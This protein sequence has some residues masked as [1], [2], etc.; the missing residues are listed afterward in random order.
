MQLLARLMDRVAGEAQQPRTIVGATSGD[1]G[2]A[3]IE[4]FRGSRARRCGDP[5]SRGPRLR[6]AAAHDDDADRGERARRRRRRH[7]RRL[8][9]AREGD[10]QRPRLPRSRVTGRRQL[11]QLGP[12]RRTGD[13]LFRRR[14][15]PRRAVPSALVLVPTGNF[16]DIFAGWVASAWA[17][18]SSAGHRLER[19][20]HPAAHARERHYEMRGVIADSSPSMDIQISSNFERYLFEASGRDASRS[21]TRCGRWRNRQFRSR[22]RSRSHAARFR[23]RRRERG[24]SRRRDP[25]PKRE[26][27]YLADPHTACGMVAPRKR[28]RHAARRRSCS[29]PPIRPS[30][31]TP[32]R[33]SPASGR[34]CPPRLA[35]CSRPERFTTV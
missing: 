4:A 2:G 10:V 31:P 7:V 25:S 34:R 16:G 19:Q 6:R 14:R 30:S 15:C 20:R 12:H 1:T 22:A 27:G 3:A 35:R 9:G 32:C 11:H 29:R 24:R 23:G 28:R 5:L 8:P 21:A 13:L 26:C 18:R 17:C 33:R